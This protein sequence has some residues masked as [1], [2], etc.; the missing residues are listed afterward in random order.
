MTQRVIHLSLPIDDNMPSHKCFQRPV[1]ILGSSNLTV[2]S[3]LIHRL[4]GELGGS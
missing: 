3:A 4:V 2:H 1:H